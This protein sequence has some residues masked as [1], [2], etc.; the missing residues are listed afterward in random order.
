MAPLRD[1][2]SAIQRHCLS[3]PE[4]KQGDTDWWRTVWHN[5]A[6]RNH[7]PTIRQFT[8]GHQ[9][10]D[11]HYWL[12]RKGPIDDPTHLATIEHSGGAAL[13]STA[14]ISLDGSTLL[15]GDSQGGVALW[16]LS[17][18]GLNRH[19]HATEV[20]NDVIVAA[21][22]AGDSTSALTIDN[23]GVVATWDL[24]NLGS[25]V[26]N[27][28][29]VNPHK[30]E[31]NATAARG[32]I[33]ITVDE[34][35]FAMWDLENELPSP[36]IA[37]NPHGDAVFAIEITE[38]RS[39]AVTSSSDRSV[40]WDLS[41]STPTVITS[42]RRLVLSDDGT[43]AVTID[44][45]RTSVWDISNDPADPAPVCFVETAQRTVSLSS[46]GA[47]AISVGWDGNIRIWDLR[48]PSDPVVTMPPLR[49]LP[50]K[51]GR[52]KSYGN[53]V[54][55]LSPVPFDLF[56]T[57]AIASNGEAAISVDTEGVAVFWDL[58]D[59]T[60]PI[61]NSVEATPHY[62]ISDASILD[63]KSAATVD[64]NGGL[65]VLWNVA[66]RTPNRILRTGLPIVQTVVTPSLAMAIT[67]DGSMVVWDLTHPGSEALNLR[68]RPL[69]LV[70][71]TDDGTRGV[72]LDQDSGL[73]LWDL[74]DPTD[75]TPTMPTKERPDKVAVNSSCTTAII[76]S[77]DGT[78][79]IWDLRDPTTT[80][81][82]QNPHEHTKRVDTIALS[83]DGNTAITTD[84]RNTNVVVWDLRDPTNPT[85]TTIKQKPHER[86]SSAVLSHD[87]TTAIT[88]DLRNTNVVVW[89]LRDPTNPTSTTIKQN[90]HERVS[91]AVLSH[92]GTTA[93]TTDLRRNAPLVV[94]DLRDPTNPTT[95]TIKQNP[96]EGTT[97]VDEIVLSGDGTTAITTDGRNTL[98]VWDLSERPPSVVGR[99]ATNGLLG[100]RPIIFESPYLVAIANEF[101]IF[102]PSSKGLSGPSL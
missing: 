55:E 39:L 66:D 40:L 81:I 36:S 76:A 32:N 35:L 62:E 56:V 25:P 5:A 18:Q 96:H 85:F 74:N 86:V 37:D 84:G 28:A 11:C 33:A 58:R 1:V 41:G 90:P 51:K 16:R 12:L 70:A 43:T 98:V 24:D 2:M 19:F 61:S 15:S 99:F 63:E 52:I 13:I 3:N 68:Q 57:G 69:N 87:G 71:L 23:S 101:E 17:G 34:S 46:D 14:N 72:G 64:Y 8:T 77:H 29:P 65:C 20:H 48:D 9:P 95:T 22:L 31:V 89:D 49:H 21:M 7:N 6:I 100:D 47:K 53:G 102:R 50:N 67:V 93:I 30:S 27:R 38:N 26:S 73:V 83:G 42:E 82:K 92:D 80:P 60:N 45:S 78:I 91:S 4:L 44:S 10:T 88:T 97:E 75:P 54:W 79:A 59:P 94:W